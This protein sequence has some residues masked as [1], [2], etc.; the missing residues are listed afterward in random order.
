MEK[1]CKFS[2][3]RYV[4]DEIRKE[5]IN[6]GLVFHSPKD[7]FVDIK[8]TTNF[9]RV[10]VF[11]D[12]VDIDLLK[13][14]LDGMKES[15]TSLEISNEG[16]FYDDLRKDDFL[17]C[18]TSFYSNQLQFSP[19]YTIRSTDVNKDFNDLFKTYVYFDS[20]RTERIT[21]D[22]VKSIMNRVIREK[23]VNINHNVSIDI[24]RE[25]I[26]LDYQYEAQESLKYI[27]TLSFDYQDKKNNRGQ[28]SRIAKEWAWNFSKM[29]Q[30]T[31]HFNGRSNKDLN[32]VTLVYV[33]KKT[34]WVEV[35][36]DIL[37]TE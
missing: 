32:I 20:R 11:D 8:F 9:S 17:D 19:I 18:A 37:K 7:M 1:M 23:E 31:H 22:K 3:L 34:E 6:I 5:F 29:K 33:G 4:P 28:E 12:E 30:S 27:K 24:G 26:K 2:V 13:T 14:V 36:L 10:H 16:P 25:R 21:I 15:F 35:A